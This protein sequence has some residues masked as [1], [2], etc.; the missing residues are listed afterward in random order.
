MGALGRMLDGY[1]RWWTK[2]DAISLKTCAKPIFQ[3]PQFTTSAFYNYSHLTV[4]G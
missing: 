3:L 2:S 1:G 4:V